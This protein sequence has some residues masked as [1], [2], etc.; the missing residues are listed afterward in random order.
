MWVLVLPTLHLKPFPNK[1]LEAEKKTQQQHKAWHFSR[2]L[3]AHSSPFDSCLCGETTSR[4]HDTKSP[5]TGSSWIS[6]QHLSWGLRCGPQS[7]P[8]ES[9][10][11]PSQANGPLRGHDTPLLQ[12]WAGAFHTQL[13]FFP[14]SKAFNQNSFRWLFSMDRIRM[15]INTE[16]RMTAYIS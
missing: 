5:A 2:V 7:W 3:T 6:T 4:E 1:K 15:V 16:G 10:L 8:L 12:K 14:L 11:S 9:A 13:R